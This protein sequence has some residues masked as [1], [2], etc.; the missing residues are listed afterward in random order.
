[1]KTIKLK[2]LKFRFYTRKNTFDETVIY[3]PHNTELRELA[4]REL[5]LELVRSLNRFLKDEGLY[6]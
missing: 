5:A 6:K 2:K 1:M 3:T 4:N